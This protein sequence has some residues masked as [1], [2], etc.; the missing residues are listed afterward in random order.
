MW[1]PDASIIITAEHKAEEAKAATLLTYKSAF[2]AHLDN[3]AQTKGYDNRISIGTYATS[4]NTIY[5]AEA[6]AFIQ[7]RDAALAS[8]FGQLAA[9]EAG[10]VAPTV[11]K[12]IAALPV[13]KWP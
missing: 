12:L 8:M 5:V 6:Q 1:T 3:V 13:I 10:G 2:D 4:T 11:E 7:W 9:V